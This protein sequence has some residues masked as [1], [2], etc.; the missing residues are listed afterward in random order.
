MSIVPTVWKALFKVNTTDV[1]G[2]GAHATATNEQSNSTVV[3]L[4]DGGF[5]AAWEDWSTLFAGGLEPRD[6]VAQRYDY[7][8]NKAGGEIGVSSL[9]QDLDQQAPALAAL[10]DGGFLGAYQTSDAAFIGD[11]ENIAVAK[12]AAGAAFP[13]TDDF[14]EGGG[15]PIHNDTAPTITSFN[16]G[17][18]VLVFENDLAG[19]KDLS[20]YFVSATGIRSAEVMLEGGA[21]DATAP[22]AATLSDQNYVVTYRSGDDIAYTIRTSAGV[23]VA[24]GTVAS[25]ASV[26]SSP[27]VASLRG[28][29]FVVV[30]Q[31]SAAD[32]AGDAGIKMRIYSNAGVAAGPAQGVATTTAGV[33]EEPAVTGLADGGILVA[34]RDA[35]TTAILG[36]RFN[37]TGAPVG[38]QLTVADPVGADV[39]QPA[40]TLLSDGRVTVTLTSTSGANDDVYA[41]ILDPRTEVTGT[42]AAD[43]LTSRIDGATV[44]GLDG[45]DTISGFA[46]ADTI[47][48]G[49]GADRMIGS[50]GNDTYVVDD[51]GD[52]VVDN[53]GT[54]TVRS[55]V[56]YVLGASLEKLLLTGAATI[57]GTGNASDNV[58]VGNSGS[59]RLDGA[60]G[61]DNLTGGNGL[62]YLTGGAGSDRFVYTS[63]EQSRPG[64]ADRILDFTAGDRIHLASI[65]A[66]AALAGDQAFVLDTDA[67]FSAG[68]IRQTVFG[69][70]LL[71]EMN[72]NATAAA[73][74]SMLLIGRNTLLT[75][76]DFAL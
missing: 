49:T 72:T 27:A 5:V 67:S 36:Q 13:T 74:M 24:S 31:D 61:A 30:W 10:P 58:L 40:L 45:N 8:G 28:G 33:Q 6:V 18:Y 32:G 26:E 21:A 54:D 25:A 60:G 35:S 39:A 65:D 76:G 34:W 73:E 11:L 23:N 9:Y 66:N 16:D 64:V 57:G 68:E 44:L 43:K 7:L 48:G 22:D 29:G 20:S 46:G 75:S 55:S 47:D 15:G 17:S 2:A 62:D 41:V 3:A 38:T 12:L 52:I 70:N 56:S 42:S 69:A 50:A 63:T 59:N 53:S 14:R 1:P 51:A 19:N 37:A 4:T 71:I